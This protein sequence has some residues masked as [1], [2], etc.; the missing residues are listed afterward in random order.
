MWLS[1]IQLAYIKCE[2]ESNRFTHTHN[3]HVRLMRQIVERK[4]MA[5]HF[6]RMC[7]LVLMHTGQKQMGNAM[8]NAMDGNEKHIQVHRIRFL[9]TI[10]VHVCDTL[11][12]NILYSVKRRHSICFGKVCIPNKRIYQNQANEQMTLKRKWNETEQ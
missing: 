4:I 12:G 3:M 7:H 11:H 5:T 6:A 8:E 10:Y 2:S 1:S 9:G